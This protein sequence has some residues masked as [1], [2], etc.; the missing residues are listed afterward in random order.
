MI[1][2]ALLAYVIAATLLL[3]AAGIGLVFYSVHS[4]LSFDKARDAIS[5]P[6]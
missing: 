1:K 3:G 4:I 2:L 6:E 5:A